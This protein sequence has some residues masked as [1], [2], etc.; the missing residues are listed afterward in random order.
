MHVQ[1]T[2]TRRCV[3]LIIGNPSGSHLWMGLGGAGAER[4]VSSGRSEDLLA[5][6]TA[7]YLGPLFIVVQRMKSRSWRPHA[8]A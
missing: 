5:R 8:T 3:D 1:L 7:G 2:I 6:Y 4:D